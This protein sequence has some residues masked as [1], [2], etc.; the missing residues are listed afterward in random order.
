MAPPLRCIA[1]LSAAERPQTAEAPGAFSWATVAAAVLSLAL[2]GALGGVAHRFRAGPPEP[3]E[4]SKDDLYVMYRYLRATEGEKI[5]ERSERQQPS[6]PYSEIGLLSRGAWPDRIPGQEASAGRWR[7]PGEIEWGPSPSD[8]EVS[9]DVLWTEWLK[10]SPRVPIVALSGAFLTTVDDEHDLLP[11]PDPSHFRSGWGLLPNDMSGWTVTLTPTEAVNVSPQ[12]LQDIVR[13]KLGVLRIC[14]LQGLLDN[15][16]L[17]GDVTIK[18]TVG[19]D[20]RV[21]KA[22]IAKSYLPDRRVLRCLANTM[23]ALR[24]PLD[25]PKAGSAMLRFAMSPPTWVRRRLH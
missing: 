10:Q 9:F 16:V 13:R 17:Q 19:A 15:P 18:L 22:L 7:A 8:D 20:G 21:S 23:Y 12:V 11:T 4:V 25:E 2:H 5:E 6:Q 24:V 3:F 14:Y 1:S